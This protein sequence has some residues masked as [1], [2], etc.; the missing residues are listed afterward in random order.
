MTKNWFVFQTIKTLFGEKG[1]NG[2]VLRIFFSV[3]YYCFFIPSV[4]GLK[5]KNHTGDYF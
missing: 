1:I 3:V 4:K 5:V 2:V